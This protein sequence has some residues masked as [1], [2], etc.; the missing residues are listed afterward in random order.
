MTSG[1]VAGAVTVALAAVTVVLAI[2]D[3][4][5]VDGGVPL[6]I[7]AL[8]AFGATAAIGAVVIGRQPVIGA[9]LCATPL[10]FCLAGACESVW[11]SV[12]GGVPWVLWVDNWAWV[13]AIVPALGIAPLLFPTGRP[14]GP[15]WRWAGRLTVAGGTLIMLGFM[16]TPGPM[17]DLGADNP[18]VAG[19]ALRDPLGAVTGLGFVLAA[20]GV[21]GAAASL[22][23]RFRRARGVE[24]LQLK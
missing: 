15:R 13:P 22:V 21:L 19:D 11:R 16:L 23:H 17:Q 5:T 9:I 10:L 12:D 4:D 3:P 2:T 1:R 14:P 7:Y 8:L 18:L 6:G 20:V 24:R